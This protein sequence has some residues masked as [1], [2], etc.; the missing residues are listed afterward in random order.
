VTC[1]SVKSN[2]KRRGRPK[3]RKL[4]VRRCGE[5]LCVAGKVFAAKGFQ[6]T[7]V[8][9][10][11]QELGISK[12]TIYRYFSSKEKLFLATVQKG[13]ECLQEHTHR[14]LN[15]PGDP[16]TRLRAATT[17]YLE[18]FERYPLLVELFIQERVVFRG[19]RR[20]VYFEVGDA[21]QAPFRSLV[22]ELISTGRLR[23]LPVDRVLDV[24]GDL[25]YGTMFTN[26]LSGRH[27][28]FQEQAQ[29][30]L[31]VTFYGI[32]SDSERSESHE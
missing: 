9:V 18:F 13:V 27:K 8:Q 1:A 29:D 25:V 17:A 19:K 14:S 32:L 26:Y 24:M 11:A 21:A 10:I 22:K 30:I 12:G 4:K 31:D 7:D 5:I 6:N 3:D 23:K 16:L 20:S 28:S 15:A 2:S